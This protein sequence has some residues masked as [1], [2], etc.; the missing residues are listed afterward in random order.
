MQRDVVAFVLMIYAITTSKIAEQPVYPNVYQSGKSG[1]TLSAFGTRYAL[2]AGTIR[3]EHKD[4]EEIT[5]PVTKQAPI[6]LGEN[7][8]RIES[9]DPLCRGAFKVNKCSS[10]GIAKLLTLVLNFS[11]ES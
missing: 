4:Y 10:Y 1:N 3:D 8:V 5:I 6:R 7:R 11:P 2:P 9:M